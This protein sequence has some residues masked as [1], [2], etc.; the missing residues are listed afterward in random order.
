MFI[1]VSDMGHNY[2]VIIA[3]AYIL[4]VCVQLMGGKAGIAL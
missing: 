2:Y 3:M 1:D 4:T